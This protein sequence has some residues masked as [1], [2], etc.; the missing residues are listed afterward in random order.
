MTVNPDLAEYI[1]EPVPDSRPDD[2]YSPPVEVVN[3]TLATLSPEPATLPPPVDVLHQK[4]PKEKVKVCIYRFPGTLMEHVTTVNWLT[5]ALFTLYQHPRVESVLTDSISDTPVDM[6]RNRAIKHALENSFDYAIFV[7]DDMYP[8]Y[9][10]H[11]GEKPE[12]ALRF[13]PHALD[14]ALEHEGPCCVGAP[15]CC[16]PPGEE[17]LTMKWEDFETGCHTGN[18]KL[19]RFTRDEVVN[20]TGFEEV[21]ALA[22]GLMLIDLRAIQYIAKPW[23]RYEF[24]DDERTQK[25]STED[26]T[27]SRDLGLAGVRQYCFWN[28]WAGHWKTKLVKKPAPVDYRHIPQRFKLAVR[29]QVQLEQQQRALKHGT[30]NA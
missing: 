20:R 19:V 14:F 30:G 25:A 27:F 28:A 22:T 13:I 17:V 10:Q 8:D 3:P 4:Q 12:S 18:T 24:K 15:Y 9:E 29:K 5:N 21:A 23:F 26:V 7:D 11:F 6:S 2:R 1:G 16:Q